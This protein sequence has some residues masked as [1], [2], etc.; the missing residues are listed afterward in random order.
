[1]HFNNPIYFYSFFPATEVLPARNAC[2]PTWRSPSVRFATAC[3]TAQTLATSVSAHVTSFPPIAR[4]TFVTKFATAK[5][6][7]LPFARNASKER[8]SVLKREPVF[9]ESRF[10]MGSSTVRFQSRTRE[11]AEKIFSQLIL[12][13]HLTFFVMSSPIILPILP[14]V[15]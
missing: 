11:I 9:L 1:M 4:A 12:R 14:N 2:N 3:S 6:R 7:L 13:W 8:L 5:R 10:A 15:F